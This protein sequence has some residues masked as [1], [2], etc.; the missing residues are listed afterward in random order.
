MVFSSPVFLFLFFPGF[1]ALYFITPRA[2]RNI[3]IL[4][5]S[6]GFYLL[7]AGPLMLVVLA[8]VV[9]NWL[10]GFLLGRLPQTKQL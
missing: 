9:F 5:G 1:F 7:G 3:F 2:F 10:V 8:L 6:F 4:V